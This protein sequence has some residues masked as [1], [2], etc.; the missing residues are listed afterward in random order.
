MTMKHLE[1][2]ELEDLGTRLQAELD[3]TLLPAII[4]MALM[5]LSGTETQKR[6]QAGPDALRINGYV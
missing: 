2:T 5:R 1:K 6:I 3:V 4:R